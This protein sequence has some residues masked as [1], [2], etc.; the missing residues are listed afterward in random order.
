MGTK[1]PV[2]PATLR[3][4]RIALT[5]DCTRCV[6]P[7][8]VDAIGPE[9]ACRACL[10]RVA[11]PSDRWLALLKAP[12]AAALKG[13]DE[14]RA[15]DFGDDFTVVSRFGLAAPACNGCGAA[16]DVDALASTRGT[17]TCACGRTIA[18][19]EADGLLGLVHRDAVAL[20]GER[21]HTWDPCPP[22][23]FRCGRCDAALRTDGTARAIACTRCAV[24]VDVPDALWEALH[25][26]LPHPPLYLLI[27]GKR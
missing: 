11:V 8:V 16:I 6:R 14:G 3:A 20:A 18:V 19:R 12:T 9:V 7:I 25:P 13:E 23:A 21:T 15:V 1:K 2:K 17:H 22:V 24:D 4:V 5:I 10:H 27:G 26:V